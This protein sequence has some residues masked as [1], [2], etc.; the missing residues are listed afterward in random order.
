M[1]Q[2][3]ART[4]AWAC[5]D[6][7]KCTSTCPIVR[8]GA[9]YSPRRHVLA[10]N[11]GE[12]A[13]SIVHDGLYVCLTCRQCDARC[14]VEVDYTGLILGLRQSAYDETTQPECPHGGALQS[15]MR[16]MAN[17][18]TQQDRLGWLK[19]DL[20]TD[21][22]KG[23]VFYWTGCTMYYDA[24]FTDFDVHTLDGTRAAIKLLN[25]LGETPI[26]SPE[27]R[28]CGH[29]L[30]W[31][32]DRKGFESLAKHNVDLVAKSGAEVLVTSCAECLRTWRI[33]YQPLIPDD[34]PEI[35]HISEFLADQTEK[36]DLSENKQ[37]RATY[38]DPC[39]L[40]R[41][42]G[43]YD[44]P[45]ELLEAVPGVELVEMPRSGVRAICCAG[46]T[47]SNC[48]RFAK[49][50]QVERLREARDTGADVLVTA[51]P[52]CQIHLKCAMNDPNIGEEISIEMRDAAELVAE[53]LDKRDSK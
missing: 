35:L 26:V 40:G 14:P 43:V 50:I 48:D 3:A 8:A 17:G 18:G 2:L 29:D 49:K 23:R 36:L 41:H 27:E 44:Q 42:L 34:F 12:P 13:S 22:K 5:Y 38:Q 28:C 16:L 53:A 31:I 47:W 11:L 9:T 24:F 4:N 33:D 19:E 32:G 20:Q 21:P 45:R 39:R 52:K 6:C 25:A 30:L 51:C 7:G 10:A 46:S 1:Q 15:T 37:T